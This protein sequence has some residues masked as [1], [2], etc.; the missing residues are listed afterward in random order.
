LSSAAAKLAA[1][2]G[3]ESARAALAAAYDAEPFVHLLPA[4]SQPH[5]AAT[6]GSNSAQLQVEVDTDSGRLLITC[7]I[8]NLG[9]GAAG[10]ALQDAN[11]MLALPETLGLAIDGVAP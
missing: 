3:I 1:G 5:T 10:Q 2:H 4:G 7:A 8:D 11:I 6:S 9:K